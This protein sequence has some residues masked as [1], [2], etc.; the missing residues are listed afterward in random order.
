MAKRLPPRT[1]LPLAAISPPNGRHIS[2]AMPTDQGGRKLRHSP[3]CR[4]QSCGRLRGRPGQMPS[5]RQCPQ[6]CRWTWRCHSWA[7]AAAAIV[8]PACQSYYRWWHWLGHPWQQQQ[9]WKKDLHRVFNFL[10]KETTDPP[11]PPPLWQKCS[12]TNTFVI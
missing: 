1:G 8:Q 6:Y 4:R 12:K 11:T 7:E 3:R 9:L 2:A 5:G 10:L